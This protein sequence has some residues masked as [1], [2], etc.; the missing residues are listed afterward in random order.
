MTDYEH[1]S[2]QNVHFYRSQKSRSI[3]FSEKINAVRVI[4][5]DFFNE[6]FI[7]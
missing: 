3:E 7:Y 4:I 2:K 1:F 6:Q 5:L